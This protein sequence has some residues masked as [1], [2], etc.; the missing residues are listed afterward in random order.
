MLTLVATAAHADGIEPGLWR[1]INRTETGGVI[2]PPHESSK[3]L[4]ADRR[5]DLGRRFRRS[6]HGEFG[7]RANRAQLYR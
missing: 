4:T 6:P 1:I 3:C 5:G 7:V 2:G